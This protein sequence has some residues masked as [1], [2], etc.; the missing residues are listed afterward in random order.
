MSNPN[1]N[2]DAVKPS[3]ITKED[4]KPLATKKTQDEIQ[5]EVSTLVT[6]ATEINKKIDTTNEK[7]NTTNTLLKV[8]LGCFLTVV[9]G[10]LGFGWF[11]LGEIKD[12]GKEIIAESKET[13]KE[14]I[15]ENRRNNK[16]LIA[17]INDSNNWRIKIIENQAKQLAKLELLTPN[18]TE[19]KK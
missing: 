15:A 14:I 11:A 9:C 17:K 8:W 7:V 16:E 4:L 12:M 3:G 5:K 10:L 13:R 19:K 18:K 1:S 6:V 2:K